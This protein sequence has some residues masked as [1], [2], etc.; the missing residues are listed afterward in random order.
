MKVKWSWAVL[1]E[2][3]NGVRKRLMSWFLFVFYIYTVIMWYCAF[4]FFRSQWTCERDLS[5]YFDYFHSMLHR[6]VMELIFSLLHSL[7]FTILCGIVSLSSQPPEHVCVCGCYCSI[8]E[9]LPFFNHYKIDFVNTETFR[10]QIK[11]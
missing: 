6:H 8:I 2:E 7:R 3:M 11:P 9:F 10:R 5:L 4:L 1:L